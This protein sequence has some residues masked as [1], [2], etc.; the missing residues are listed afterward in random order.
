MIKVSGQ[1]TP[2]LEAVDIELIYSHS[3]VGSIDE[4]FLPVGKRVKFTTEYGLLL[5]SHKETGSKSNWQALNDSDDVYIERP[6]KD[7]LKFSFSV[8]HF[9]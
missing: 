2:F 9:C 8:E 3:D 4:E 6:R 5:R 7:Q 1:K